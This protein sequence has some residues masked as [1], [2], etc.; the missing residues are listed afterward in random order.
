R[1]EMPRGGEGEEPAQKQAP[2]DVD[3]ER[4]QGKSHREHPREPQPHSPAGQ[5]ADKSRTSHRQRLNQHLHLHS[6]ATKKKPSFHWN[7]GFTCGRE[8]S[9][10]HTLWV[11]EPES[12]ASANSA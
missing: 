8:E 5:R 3:D 7:E 9:N 6:A 4:A 12:C 2:G 11:Q 10:L 1:N